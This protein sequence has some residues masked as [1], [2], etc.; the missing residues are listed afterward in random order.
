MPFES[1]CVSVQGA[2]H[3]KRGMPREDY[4]KS[5]FGSFFDVFAVADGHGD[6]N[7]PRSD[8]GSRF[9][10][11][12]A[13]DHLMSFAQSLRATATN[14]DAADDDVWE[15]DEHAMLWDASPEDPWNTDEDPLADEG[16]IDSATNLESELFGPKEEPFVRQLVRSIVGHWNEKV[17]DHFDANPLT[18]EER[19]GCDRYLERYDRNERIEHIYGTT[20]IAGLFTDTYVLLLQQ[21]D[22]RCVLFDGDGT[23]TQ[24]IPWDNRCVANVCTS[25]CDADAIESFRYF[26]APREGLSIAACLA[27]SDG[28]EDSFF[29]MD[30]MHSYY[31]DLLCYAVEHGVPAL[32]SHLEDTLGEFSAKG[33]QDDVTICGLIDLERVA[34]LVETFRRQNE[35]V[36]HQSR[37]SRIADR[38]ESMSGK[39]EYLRN[40]VASACEQADE[41]KRQLERLL[42]AHQI[43]KK[44]L[45]S[46]QPHTFTPFD[47]PA[48]GFK[49]VLEAGHARQWRSKTESKLAEAD[50]Q[51]E[52][53]RRSSDEAKRQLEL[54]KKELRDYEDEHASLEQALAEQ[55]G[56]IQRLEGSASSESVSHTLTDEARSRRRPSAASL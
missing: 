37:R 17:N 54:A 33:S 24:P 2:G 44:E 16:T 56:D 38:L 52:Q 48:S 28:V 14:N 12:I 27:G 36:D 43:Y 53:A 49:I 46:M 19:A 11:E 23:A 51:L 35:L 10:C 1:V 6:S 7:C 4:G 20:L 50:A 41:K 30:Q 26:V 29:S 40:R 34:P 22:G 21:G 47:S 18:E 55:D 9:A 5:S 39:M 25:L 42:E 31:R 13:V 8:L 15:D 3:K 45:D 32:K